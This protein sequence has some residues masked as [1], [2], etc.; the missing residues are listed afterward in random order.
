[1]SI[2]EKFSTPWKICKEMLVAR[3]YTIKE[4][5]TDAIKMT[6]LDQKNNLVYIFF[7]T[8]PKLNIKIAQQYYYLINTKNITHCIIIYNDTITS[9]V[10]NTLSS[11]YGIRVELFQLKELEFNLTKHCLVPKHTRIQKDDNEKEYSKFPIL[12]ANDPVAK[13]YGYLSN[14]LIKIERR[15]GTVSYRIVK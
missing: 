2:V 8:E 11:F 15:D 13:F 6:A 7:I 12:R 3:G 9:T 10:R 4:E 5:D 1:M 14:D